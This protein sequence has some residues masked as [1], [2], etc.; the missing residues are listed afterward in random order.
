[1][2]L[3]SLRKVGG[4]VM[5]AVPPVLLESLD[6]SA[7]ARVGLTVDEGH[8]IIDPK[9]KPYYELDDLLAQCAERTGFSEEEREW[10]D[11][12]SVGRE[13]I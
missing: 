8:L 13:L 3:T 6:L 7:G 4:S 1:M 5:L 11:A 9:P 12:P 10:L 2:Y